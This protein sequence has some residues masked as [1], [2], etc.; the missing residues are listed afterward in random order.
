LKRIHGK[1]LWTLAT[2]LFS[3]AAAALT[4]GCVSAHADTYS[5]PITSYDAFRSAVIGNGYDTDGLYYKDGLDYS[6]QCWDGANLLWQQLGRTLN[7]G[8]TGC[9]YGTWTVDWA[10]EQNAGS[11]FTLI[12]NK[13][14]VKRGDVV[15]LGS[16]A[17]DG[18][19]AIDGPGHVG[20]ADADWSSGAA[21]QLILDQNFDG[22]KYFSS[23]NIITTS[24]LGAFRLKRWNGQGEYLDMGASFDGFLIATVPWKHLTIGA[25]GTNVEL[26]CDDSE[27]LT[28]R[29]AWH[30]ERQSD[31]SYV[32]TSLY[33]GAVLEVA[34]GSAANGANVQVAWK[35]TG[36]DEQRFYFM[37]GLRIVPKC[38]TGSSLDVTGGTFADGTNI[39]IWAQNSS[40][41]QKIRSYDNA[42]NDNGVF[43]TSMTVAD[44]LTVA[45]GAQATIAHSFSPADAVPNRQGIT[46]ESW[47]PGVAS[48][49]ENGV[50]TGVM[51]GST[52]VTAQSKFNDHWYAECEVTVVSGIPAS[53]IT[54]HKVDGDQLHVEWTESPTTSDDDVRTYT[55]EIYNNLSGEVY[56]SFEGLTVLSADFDLYGLTRNGLNCVRVVAVDETTGAS[57]ASS[58]YSINYLGESEPQASLVMHAGETL[59]WEGILTLF[60]EEDR[61]ML[62]N[63]AY[64]G[65]YK[66]TSSD[67]SVLRID[68]VTSG[69]TN[70]YSKKSFVALQPGTV[71][72]SMGYDD[73]PNTA[74][75]MTVYVLEQGAMAVTLPAGLRTIED[76]AFAGAS[77]TEVRIPDGCTSIGSRAFADNASLRTIVIPASVTSIAWDA[78]MLN[79]GTNWDVTIWCEEGSEAAAFAQ[80]WG[81]LYRYME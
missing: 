20:F 25:S 65:W 48:V 43:P 41:A 74:R 22:R 33:G 47:D 29:E 58:P 37:D 23:H 2:A 57:Q 11:D 14:N 69:Y 77:F 6:Y 73:Q 39:E 81:F 59:D 21:V 60:R 76:E 35:K 30:F 4:L 8:D 49:D 67:E 40:D 9:A 61:G 12:T 3:L 75:T 28:A 18:T 66:M 64:R 51:G 27:R 78:F 62:D 26:D 15:V 5:V 34:G 36:G 44:M 63:V 80:R 68:V 42:L 53:K 7:T 38:A 10:R 13:N 24:F 45:A 56:R 50:V 52:K 55:I 46:W 70:D 32:I 1:A 79:N 17:Y 71:E 54:E 16:Y 31:L 19:W 72:I